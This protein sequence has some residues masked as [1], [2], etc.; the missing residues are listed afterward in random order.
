MLNNDSSL[1]GN[2]TSFDWQRAS[3]RVCVLPIGAFEQHSHHLPLSSDDIVAE[4]F[5]R[6]LARELGAALLPILN[7]GTS[8]EQTGFHGTIT[9]RPET[10][11]Q[12]VRDIAGEVERQEFATMVILNAH[13][14]NYALAPVVRDVNRMNRKLKMLIAN[15][16]EFVDGDIFESAGLGKPD[17]HAGEF[18]TSLIMALKPERVKPEVV[19]MIPTEDNF[20]QTDLNTF[21]MGWNAP[22][23]A[24]GSPS[25]ASKEKGEKAIA[26]IERNMLAYVRERLDW[27]AKD[28]SY[29]GK[30]MGS[31]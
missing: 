18:E 6:F 16:W 14:G 31:Q 7:Y 13:G 11:M 8:L 19:D 25:L 9:L 17:I 26:S 20:R 30:E 15:Y 2:K 27:L 21:G 1:D 24:F 28:R 5:A 23:G 29:N 10:L 4:H 12:I 22:E 3:P